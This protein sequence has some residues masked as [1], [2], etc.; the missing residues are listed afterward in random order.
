MFLPKFNAVV[1]ENPFLRLSTFM[2]TIS[3]SGWGLIDFDLFWRLR[4]NYEL[5]YSYSCSLEEDVGALVWSLW[6]G[7]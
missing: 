1:G 5:P 6:S 7:P 4:A 3:D 2:H